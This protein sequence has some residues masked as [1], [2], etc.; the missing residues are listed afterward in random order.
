MVESGS[1]RAT[2]VNEYVVSPK[3]GSVCVLWRTS[4]RSGEYH[5]SRVITMA[6]SLPIVPA[7]I[8]FVVLVPVTGM[9]SI[10]LSPIDAV[11]T[12]PFRD[13]PASARAL[14]AN[15]TLPGPPPQDEDRRSVCHLP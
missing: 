14:I 6:L 9:P 15:A 2:F 10:A 1:L 3:R 7:G 12:S 5:V 8:V 4:F 11:L 13:S